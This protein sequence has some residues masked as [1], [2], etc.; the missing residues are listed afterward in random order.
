MVSSHGLEGLGFRDKCI[1][2][3]VCITGHVF[4]KMPKP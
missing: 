2:C 1:G 4:R 3:L